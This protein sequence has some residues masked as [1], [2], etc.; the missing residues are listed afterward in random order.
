MICDNCGTPHQP[1]AL[2][3]PNCGGTAFIYA[4]SDGIDTGTVDTLP[5]KPFEEMP[6]K[7]FSRDEF[8]AQLD[9]ELRTAIESGF[10]I[11]DILFTPRY[12]QFIVRPRLQDI[13][14]SLNAV[15]EQLKPS[16][17]VPFLQLKD[18]NYVL[19]LGLVPPPKPSTR[20]WLP[21]VL[22]FATIG[23]TMYAGYGISIGFLGLD[24]LVFSWRAVGL[25]ALFSF[26]IMSILGLHELSHYITS[27][28]AGI[29][30]TFP[31]FIPVPLFPLGT[32]GAFIQIKSPINNR[33][34]LLRL[35]F[36]GPFMSFIL[37]IFAL[38]IGI[39]LSVVQEVTSEDGGMLLGSSLLFEQLVLLIKGS[40]PE[41]N[42]LYLHPVAFAGWVGLFITSINLIPIGQLDGGHISRSI[43]GE[44]WAKRVGYIAFIVLLIMG[45]TFQYEGWYLWAF[46][47]YILGG[48]G[49]HPIDDVT[50]VD[51]KHLVIGIIAIVVF[52][53]SFIPIPFSIIPSPT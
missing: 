40:Y 38:I 52:I 12:A 17:R 11:L 25:S 9:S 42:A 3:C 23:T 16:G 7:P 39:Q 44:V 29:T 27:R 24:S 50:P 35:G 26:S 31:Y 48:R 49:V 28:R 4:P 18:G 10:E 13:N 36:S 34:I 14:H 32:M 20:P 8:I 37:A 30:A 2:E 43:L 47:A 51:A 19:F 41:G 53:L 21:L 1:G 45:F 46:I 6:T 33:N 15:I 22:F 5:R